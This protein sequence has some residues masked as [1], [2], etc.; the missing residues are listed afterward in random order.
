LAETAWE[1]CLAIGERP[2][3]EGSVEG[4]GSHLARHNLDV[5]RQQLALLGGG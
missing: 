4:R 2:E 1:R 5:L 3:L